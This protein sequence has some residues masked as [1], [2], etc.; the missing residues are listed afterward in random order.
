[1]IHLVWWDNRHLSCVCVFL[2]V[3]QWR[4]FNYEHKQTTPVHMFW[5]TVMK[6]TPSRK[7]CCH[8]KKG[9]RRKTYRV[10]VSSFQCRLSLLEAIIIT[11]SSVIQSA[12]AALMHRCCSGNES[13]RTCSNKLDLVS[14]PLIHI[15]SGPCSSWAMCLWSAGLM[16][17]Y[18]A[19]VNFLLSVTRWSFCLSNDQRRQRLNYKSNFLPSF[20][21]QQSGE[22][23]PKDAESGMNTCMS[24]KE[25]FCAWRRAIPCSRPC[26][27]SVFVCDQKHQVV[28]W[29]MP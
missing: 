3:P 25:C 20:L 27:P 9:F 18:P 26:S 16:T 2:S 12:D 13:T 19:K 14:G 10:L 24:C 7:R 15:S 28:A 22:K 21:R 11:I 23:E 1:M 8:R 4:L 6:E 29:V 17:V 5:F